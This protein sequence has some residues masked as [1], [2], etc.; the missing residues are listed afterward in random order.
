MSGLVKR[1]K[2]VAALFFV[3]LLAL[4]L[5][6]PAPAG[7]YTVARETLLTEPVTRGVTL[8]GYVQ[9]T[10]AGPLK[11]NVLRVDLTDPYVRLDVLLGGDGGSFGNA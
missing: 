7:A 4:Y 8:T 5:S 9:E 6:V 3:V 1:R 11:V 10:D 2:I